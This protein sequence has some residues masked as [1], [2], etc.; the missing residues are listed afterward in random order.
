[1]LKAVR[2]CEG[3]VWGM[4]LIYKQTSLQQKVQRSFT[5]LLQKFYFIRLGEIAWIVQL[6]QV[7]LPLF[8]LFSVVRSDLSLKY[9]CHDLYIEGVTCIENLVGISFLLV[10]GSFCI[11][12]LCLLLQSDSDLMMVIGGGEFYSF[13]TVEALA[14][15]NYKDGSII[16]MNDVVSIVCFADKVFHVYFSSNNEHLDPKKKKNI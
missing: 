2:Q 5:V 7:Q 8:N 9:K 13:Q 3:Y 6:Y 11:F 10:R 16:V 15:S 4:C 1:M 12:I 14:W